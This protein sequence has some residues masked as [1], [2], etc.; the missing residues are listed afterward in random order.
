M[1]TFGKNTKIK[2]IFGELEINIEGVQEVVLEMDN[3]VRRS[4]N[5]TE[6]FQRFQK[7]WFDSIDQVFA[8]GG[9]PVEWPA[10][11]P[12]YESRKAVA[13]PGQPIMRASDRLYES[14]T[15]Q[16]SD[17]IW[18][19]GPRHIEFGSRVPYFEYH[20][21]GTPTMDAR[22]VLVLTDDAADQLVEM[23]QAYVVDGRVE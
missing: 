22:P 16:T 14:L 7:H 19:V 20:Q 11:S 17:T 10:L 1:T 9:D 13:F 18:K 15:S 5:L 3:L 21:Q 12:A 6:P 23:V 2:F 8:D 4:S